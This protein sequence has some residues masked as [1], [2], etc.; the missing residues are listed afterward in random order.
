VTQTPRSVELQ[1][2][3]DSRV[4]EPWPQLLAMAATAGLYAGGVLGFEA[5][6]V[7]VAALWWLAW[8]QA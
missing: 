7:G 2:L 4:A 6:V 1:R 5:L 8:P 3:S